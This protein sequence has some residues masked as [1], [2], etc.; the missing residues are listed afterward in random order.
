L[1]FAGAE[2]EEF[3]A[4][5][6]V[7]AGYGVKGCLNRA[8]ELCRASEAVDGGGRGVLVVAIGP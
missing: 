1:V 7:L 2:R 4:Q 5:V 3:I 6:R 8:A